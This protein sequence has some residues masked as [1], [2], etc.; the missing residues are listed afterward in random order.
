M[1][2]VYEPEIAANIAEYVNYFCPVEG[3]KEI[4][5]KRNPELANNQL[6]ADITPLSERDEL[7]HAFVAMTSNLRNLVTEVQE[8]QKQIIA[9]SRRLSDAGQMVLAGRGDD[10]V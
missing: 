1:N 6:Q 3:V 4:L 7:G 2:Y 5:T 8:A 9:V 10:Y